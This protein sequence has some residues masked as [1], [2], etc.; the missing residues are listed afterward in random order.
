MGIG[1]VLIRMKINIVAGRDIDGTNSQAEVDVGIPVG[2][3]TS[4]AVF[5]FREAV[6]DLVSDLGVVAANKVVFGVRDRCV[7][8]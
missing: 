6:D 5:G 3:E 1:P 2:L 8:E 7:G 4:R